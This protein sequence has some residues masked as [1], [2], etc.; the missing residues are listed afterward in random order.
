MFAWYRS[1][2]TDGQDEWWTNTPW[3]KTGGGGGEEGGGEVSFPATPTTVIFK[4]M[5][6]PEEMLFLDLPG[7]TGTTGIDVRVEAVPLGQIAPPMP[8]FDTET[9]APF[10]LQLTDKVSHGTTYYVW[11]RARN[12]EEVSDWA[13]VV[14]LDVE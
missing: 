7:Y 6:F 8:D 12:G 2:H 11:V 1:R 9:N 4:Y 14:R 3:G 10:P 5:T 13:T